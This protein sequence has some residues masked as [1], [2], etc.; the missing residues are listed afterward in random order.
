MAK[1]GTVL[2]GKL[3]RARGREARRR[4]EWRDQV[5]ALNWRRKRTAELL[6][7]YRRASKGEKP[8]L[9][10]LYRLSRGLA[11]KS[12]A[13]A[14]EEG[15]EY[16]EA[17]G[18]R[19]KWEKALARFREFIHR[20][21]PHLSGDLDTRPELLRKLERLARDIGRNL[22]LTS[23]YRSP[24]EQKALYDNRHSNPYPVA[25]CC[26]CQSRHCSKRA[27]DVVIGGVAIQ[28]V[29][30][31]ATLRRHGLEPLSGDAVHVE[32]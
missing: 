2:K 21:Y 7:S 19:V 17:R 10:K 6:R 24:A 12:R 16:R 5:R 14:V 4:D 18:N 1:R 8:S 31:S 32:G 22:Y 11:A 26:P 3:R 13:A 30:S 28:H 20:P 9:L 27:A 15:A 29:V 25:F 23:G